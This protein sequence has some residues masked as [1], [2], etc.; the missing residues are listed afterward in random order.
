MSLKA[1][2]AHALDEQLEELGVDAAAI[3][4]HRYSFDEDERTSSPLFD[5]RGTSP[6]LCAPLPPQP[7]QQRAALKPTGM[8][9]K[10]NCAHV[11]GRESPTRQPAPS[12][13]E[14]MSPPLV[15]RMK[16]PL[17]ALGL[18]SRTLSAH[19]LAEE[20][21]LLEK[22]R[23]SCPEIGIVSPPLSPDRSSPYASSPSARRYLPGVV[24]M[25]RDEDDEDEL[26]ADVVRAP[27]DAQRA[28]H[29][30]ASLTAS[31]LLRSDDEF[32]FTPAFSY[33][34]IDQSAAESSAGVGVGAQ[35]PPD[36]SSSLSS[37]TRGANPFRPTSNTAGGDQ[38]RGQPHAVPQL[39]SYAQSAS[40]PAA[41]GDAALYEYG[42]LDI[43]QVAASIAEDTARLTSEIDRS[44]HLFGVLPASKLMP[45]PPPPPP[46]VI[47][48]DSR[49]TPPD[50]CSSLLFAHEDPWKASGSLAVGS[51][52]DVYSAQADERLG[53][54]YG[55]VCEP[56]A[57]Y[58]ASTESEHW[59]ASAPASRGMQR[60]HSFRD[61]RE[62]IDHLCV[63]E[64]EH[65]GTSAAAADAGGGAQDVAR[66]PAAPAEAFAAAVAAAAAAACA[67]APPAQSSTP[68]RVLPSAPAAAHASTGG[69]DV[70][71][72]A[73]VD[74]DVDVDASAAA[75]ATA[76]A[77]VRAHTHL[78][79]C[80][81]NAS[82]ARHLPSGVSPQRRASH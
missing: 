12:R 73:D 75:A 79:H 24:H 63:C 41:A 2:G 25:L 38:L 21:A 68:R 51:D 50:T 57:S 39:A 60:T 46:L 52:E 9:L 76:L 64:R 23:G 80:L 5:A 6:P 65:E 43:A 62:T 74:V 8:T 53:D 28:A 56:P 29:E 17:C 48:T 78:Q 30:L 32:F 58:E 26:A 31:G 22:R 14:F 82:L 34:A 47:A 66:S 11:D 1:S 70:H 61:L 35:V 19:S 55:D 40:A 20:S 72:D 71:L 59:S 77:Q 10:L 7:T 33:D 15:R 36:S 4:A 37:L 16:R 54:G 44:A 13:A 3:D 27:R 18:S 67:R 45:W 69:V 49:D 81:L 42:V